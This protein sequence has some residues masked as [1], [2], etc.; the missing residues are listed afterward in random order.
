MPRPRTT[1]RRFGSSARWAPTTT[2]A[3]CYLRLADILHPPGRSRSGDRRGAP[4]HRD[5]RGDRHPRASQCSPGSSWPTSRG[6]PAI[7]PS[8]A[9]CATTALARIAA[10]PD[11]ASDA[12]PRDV[13]VAL[14]L[15]AKHQLVDGEI[16]QARE[17]LALAYDAAVGTRDMPI[18]ALVG[19]VAA[20]FAEHDGDPIGGRRASSARRLGYAAPTT[21]PN[22]TSPSS[23]RGCARNSATRI[24]PRPTNGA[25]HSTGRTRSNA[26]ARARFRCGARRREGPAG[27]RPATVRPSNRASRSGWTRSHR[28]SSARG[29]CRPG[30]RSG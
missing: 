14:A 22:P 21:P 1:P 4:R 28:W 23:R 18:I 13:A 2:R 26:S 25:A 15:A 5:Q 16:D 19:V 27:R 30:A 3:G 12:G 11:R 7:S 6:G 17:R 8:P 20:R 9:G 24:M 10:M 29:R